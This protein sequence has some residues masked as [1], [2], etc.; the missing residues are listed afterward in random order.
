M[1]LLSKAD[2]LT[3]DE[4]ER[5]VAYLRQQLRAQTGTETPVYPVSV[6]GEHAVLCERWFE[7]A[8]RPQLQEQRRLAERSLRRKI[9][10]LREAVIAALHKRLSRTG[11]ATADPQ[12][13]AADPALTQALAQLDAA[14]RGGQRGDRQVE[15]FTG[16]ILDQV[17]QS[18]A[19]REH[20]H[21]APPDDVTDVAASA[22]G[23]GAQAMAEATARSLVQIRAA[24]VG[25]LMAARTAL[26]TPSTAAGKLP[27][28]RGMPMLDGPSVIGSVRLH[29]PPLARILG[30]D[31]L[32]RRLKKQLQARTGPELSE[33]LS[34]YARAL[35]R[36]RSKELDGLRRA[37][38][39]DAELL[40]GQHQP[41]P[42]GAENQAINRQAVRDDIERLRRWDESAPEARSPAEVSA[43]PGAEEAVAEP[44]AA[45]LTIGHEDSRR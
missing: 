1:V 45:K 41:G 20:A 44:P 9:G 31:L 33:V 2:V 15:P 25:A 19:A 18:A 21:P 43:M 38:V 10:A 28:A 4:R 34:E 30:Q 26:G 16:Q 13:Q 22:L 3:S 11:P 24:A 40:R 7:S 6:K 17:A 29:V 35:E 14:R 39:A 32:R 5:T 42:L 36:W 8:L 23:R 12:W 37:L 27:E